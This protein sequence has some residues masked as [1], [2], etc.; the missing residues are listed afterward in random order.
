MKG[1]EMEAKVKQ[2]SEMR[3]CRKESAVDFLSVWFF[4]GLTV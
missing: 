1:R 3:L 2:Q 4:D